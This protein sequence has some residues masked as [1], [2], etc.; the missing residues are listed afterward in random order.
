M[1]FVHCVDKSTVITT[2]DQR[3]VELC[4]TMDTTY[5]NHNI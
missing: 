2:N 4:T 3:W 1:F 5:T